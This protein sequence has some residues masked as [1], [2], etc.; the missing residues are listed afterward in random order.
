MSLLELDVIRAVL[1]TLADAVAVEVVVVKVDSTA[2]VAGGADVKKRWSSRSTL[3]TKCI[4][5]SP[6]LT[7]VLKH[8]SS[9]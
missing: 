1:Y 7:I 3:P 9:L 2:R 5:L 8:L 6:V 4:Y